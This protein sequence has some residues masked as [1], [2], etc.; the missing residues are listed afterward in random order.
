MTVSGGPSKGSGMRAAQG[1]TGRLSPP[2]GPGSSA[3]FSSSSFQMDENGMGS[4]FSSLLMHLSPGPSQQLLGDVTEG[5]R[6]KAACG[7][8]SWKCQ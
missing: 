6:L 1:R 7:P 4:P 8:T 2:S 3:P 5:Q